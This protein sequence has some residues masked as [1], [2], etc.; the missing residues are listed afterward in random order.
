[1]ENKF[2][3]LANLRHGKKNLFLR[4]L[5]KNMMASGIPI[6]NQIQI[7][8]FII[9]FTVFGLGLLINICFRWDT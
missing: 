5:R 7:E 6:T 3:F 8:A 1:M 2:T 4:I 9:E